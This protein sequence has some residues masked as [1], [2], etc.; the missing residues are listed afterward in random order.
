MTNSRATTVPWHRNDLN[1]DVR[2]KPGIRNKVNEGP[3]KSLSLI[4]DTEL[5][6]KKIYTWSCVKMNGIFASRRR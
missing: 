6:A 3:T 2:V 4:A 5:L 1:F